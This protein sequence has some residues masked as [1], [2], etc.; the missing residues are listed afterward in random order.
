MVNQIYRWFVEDNLFESEIAERLNTQGVVTDL[1]RPWTRGTVRGVLSN[2]KYI[3]NNIYNR[4]SF[5]LKKLRVVNGPEMWIRKDGAFEGI[6]PAEF[7]HGA[8]HSACGP[9][10]TAMRS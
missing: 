3:G 4:R 2:E 6:V 5:K 7:T 8:R 10:A 9:I 1:Q